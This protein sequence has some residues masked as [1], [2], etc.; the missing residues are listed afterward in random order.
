MLLESEDSTPSGVGHARN[1]KL[2]MR[3][4]D[5]CEVEIEKIGTLRNVV[6]AEGHGLGFPQSVIWHAPHCPRIQAAGLWRP[7]AGGGLK[8]PDCFNQ[9]K[10]KENALGLS[11]RSFAGPEKRLGGLVP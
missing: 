4:G 7:T 11:L 8:L 9:L 10:R 2:Y 3:P 1:P 5:V 6:R